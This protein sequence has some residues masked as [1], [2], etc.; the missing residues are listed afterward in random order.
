MTI[1]HLRRDLLGAGT[2]LFVAGCLGEGTGVDVPSFG[3][4]TEIQG[5]RVSALFVQ[6]QPNPPDLGENRWSLRITDDDGAPRT[7]LAV[8]L[9]PFMP[10][11]GHG[12]TPSRFPATPGAEEGSYDCGPFDLFMPGTWEF[13]LTVDAAEEFTDAIIWSLDVEG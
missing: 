7:D 4:G 8:T 9:E 1:A 11:H 13:T 12:T 6:V 2:L 10:A 5:E 3:P